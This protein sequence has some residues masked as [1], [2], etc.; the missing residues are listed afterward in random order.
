MNKKQTGGYKREGK[1]KKVGIKRLVEPASKKEKV[2][3]EKPVVTKFGD[4]VNKYAKRQL[5]KSIRL[6]KKA[7]KQEKKAD[8]A[9]AVTKKQYGTKEGSLFAFQPSGKR[10]RRRA[11][12]ALTKAQAG[13]RKA[14]REGKKAGIYKTGGFIEPPTE[15]I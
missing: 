2:T 8:E 3:A 10:S 5:K 14:Y 9:R 6:T 4:R 15:E 13:S 1:A 12:K 11:K 7:E